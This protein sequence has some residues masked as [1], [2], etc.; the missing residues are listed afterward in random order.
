MTHDTACIAFNGD[1][2]IA[3]GSV[4]DV[5]KQTKLQLDKEPNAAILIFEETTSRL[6]EIDFRGTLDDVLKR[7]PKPEPQEPIRRGP[8]RPRLGVVSREITLLPRHWDW[9]S[10]QS[11]GASV[12]L[13][14]LVE[15]ASKASSATDRIREAREVCYRFMTVMAGDRSNFEDATR[16]LYAGNKDLFFSQIVDWPK[17]IKSHLKTLAEHAFPTTESE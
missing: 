12:V 15:Q 8:G 14:R 1:Q 2:V 10:K 9:L 17:D 6:V 4:H 7:L 5:A 3:S 11:G 13:R 16:A